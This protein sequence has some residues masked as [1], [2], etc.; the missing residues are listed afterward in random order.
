MAAS[1]NVPS[2]SC[3]FGGV[4]VAYDSRSSSVPPAAKKSSAPLVSALCRCDW[5]G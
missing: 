3:V 1:Q 5:A 4:G 2:V